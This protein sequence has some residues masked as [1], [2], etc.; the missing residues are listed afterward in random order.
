MHISSFKP[1]EFGI[2]I[3]SALCVEAGI[4]VMLMLAGAGTAL[5]SHEQPPPPV[6]PIQITPVIE[7]VPLLKL[8]SKR[9]ENQLPDMWRKP[10]P[11]PR[12]EDKSAAS[13]VADKNPAALP[14]NEMAKSDE[15]PA[16]EDAELAKK[17]DEMIPDETDPVDPNL[18]EEGAADG[19]AEG[20]ETDPLKAFVIDQY[21][22]KLIAWF[23]QG[24]DSPDGAEYCDISALVSAHV[25]ADRVV[26]SFTLTSSGNPAFDAK[27]RAHL[28]R[29]VG[30]QLPPPPPKYPELAEST[31]HPR[32]SGENSACKDS[33]S[34]KPAKAAPSPEPDSP[35]EPEAPQAPEAPEP[36]RPDPPGGFFAE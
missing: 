16:P 25:G 18:P 26:Q 33:K 31:V 24:F 35:S 34:K 2:A 10:K 11:K 9:A 29:K 13:P 28:Q 20:T 14:T 4:A 17:V 15:R 36:A 5:S 32:F 3:G 27:V 19:I 22:A 21:K 23:K 1:T 8:G 7:D 30:Q 12:Y 6:M